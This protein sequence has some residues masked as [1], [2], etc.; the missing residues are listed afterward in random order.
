MAVTVGLSQGFRDGF[1][2]MQ[3]F[4]F[5]TY[6]CHSIDISLQESVIA[7]PF[8]AAIR[9][10]YQDVSSGQKAMTRDIVK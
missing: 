4:G 7:E 8:L 9:K 1:D 3:R 10:L 6:S 5:T 2:N